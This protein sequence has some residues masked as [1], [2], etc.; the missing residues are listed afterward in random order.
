MFYHVCDEC[1][2][3]D[4]FCIVNNVLLTNRRS[5]NEEQN[6]KRE[7]GRERNTMKWIGR[8]VGLG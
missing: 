1:V 4:V 3:F 6:D 5:F 7:N 8:C 2:L